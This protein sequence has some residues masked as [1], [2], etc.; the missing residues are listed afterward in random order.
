MTAQNL[1]TVFVSGNQLSLS[2]DLKRRVLVCDLFCA[3]EA[4][5]RDFKKPIADS[6]PSNP[7]TRARFLAALWSLVNHWQAQ[8]CPRLEERPLPSFETFS[9]IIGRLV[10]TANFANPNAPPE[11]QM[12]EAEQA[13]KLLLRAL[14][15]AVPT[16]SS[17]DY[18]R[19]EAMTQATEIGFLDLLTIGAKDDKKAFGQRIAKWKGRRFLDISGREFKFGNGRSRNS[20]GALYPVIVFAE[21]VA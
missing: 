13:W 4:T 6:W 11:N 2:A 10:T 17:R 20:L 1:A 21:E 8:R 5:E 7:E 18:T 14:A 19:E 15:D 3:R 16:G 12:D 9:A